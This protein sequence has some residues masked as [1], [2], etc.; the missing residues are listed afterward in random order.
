MSRIEITFTE[1]TQYSLNT[2]RVFNFV[3]EAS[4]RKGSEKE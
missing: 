2:Q 3:T 1:I 4:S